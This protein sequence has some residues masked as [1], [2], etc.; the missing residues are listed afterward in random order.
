MNLLMNSP[1]RA[2]LA[3][4]WSLQV[5]RLL[6]VLS[7]VVRLCTLSWVWCC[8]AALRGQGDVRVAFNCEVSQRLSSSRV[9]YTYAAALA[10]RLPTF[11][12]GTF[13]EILTM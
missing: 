8:A 10:A 11:A 9:L 12:C 5:H 1:M 2:S 6:R 13:Y 4:L 7:A 3:S